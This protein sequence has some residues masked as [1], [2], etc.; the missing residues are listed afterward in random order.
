MMIMM[1]KPVSALISQNPYDSPMKDDYMLSKSVC[2]SPEDDHTNAMMSPSSM[3]YNQNQDENLLS[4]H[5][6]EVEVSLD[7][8]QEHLLLIP[9]DAQKEPSK[10]KVNKVYSNLYS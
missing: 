3:F 2:D 7:S 1:M 9:Q 10:P 6:D 4:P 5:A 8:F